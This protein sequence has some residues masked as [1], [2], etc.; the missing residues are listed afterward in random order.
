MRKQRKANVAEKKGRLY[1]RMTWTEGGKRK[2]RYI[3]LPGEE[4]SHEF[5][6]AYWAIRSGKS[7]AVRKPI[8]TTWRVLGADYRASHRY[9]KLSTGSRR[10]Y[11]PV[12]EELL[13]K[14]GDK[15]VRKVTRQQLRQIHAKYAE[16]P[17]AADHRIQVI[18]IL[19]NWAK[20]ELEWINDNP[21]DGITLYGAQTEYEPWSQEA[22]TA[23]LTAARNLEEWDA[24]TAFML[25]TNTGQ[26]A[27]DLCKME[28]AHYDGIGIWVTQEKTT[29]RLYVACPVK[30]KE[31]L[32]RIPRKGKYILAKNLRQ[33]LGYNSIQKKVK[34]VRDATTS[35]KDLVIHG[36]RYTAA[37]ALAEAGCRDAEIQ[38][39]TG[40]KTMAM[41]QKYRK[42][43]SQ[44]ALSIQAQG[45]RK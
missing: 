9:K 37:V 42:Q 23:F 2:E 32:D 16:T 36:W 24:L 3:P 34:R 22:Q 41:V 15:D 30:L 4:H 1:Y 43:A 7:D 31:Y 44:M 20:I 38:S 12:I 39:V 8:K 28:W 27:G 25:G 11:D 35:C 40:H 13:A 5:D 14:N 33:P 17:R 29:A 45:R 26:R 19:L 18:R 6:R 21:A 10:K